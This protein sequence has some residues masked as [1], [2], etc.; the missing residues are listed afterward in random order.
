MAPPYLAK[1][2]ELATATGLPEQSPR[3][4]LALQRASDRFRGAVGHPVHLVEDDEIWLDGNG[5]DTLLLPAA[6]I[7]S[8]SVELDGAALVAGSGYKISRRAGIL[9]RAGGWPDDLENVKVTYTHG[10]DEIP[11]DIA[12]AV[13]EQATT[14]ALVLAH[15]GAQGMGP[16]NIK[17]EAAATVGVTQ[18]WTDAVE[19]YNLGRGDRS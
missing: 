16:A 12:D 4:L 18:K 11:G 8:I 6:P 17:Y 3:L 14:Q 13:L 19:K 2:T 7:T 9:R 15:V 1:L 10:Y 5:T